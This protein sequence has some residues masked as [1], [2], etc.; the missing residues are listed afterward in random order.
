MSELEDQLDAILWKYDVSRAKREGEVEQRSSQ[1]A[2]KAQK[3]RQIIADVVKPVFDETKQKLAQRCVVQVTEGGWVAQHPANYVASIRVTLLP[4]AGASAPINSTSPPTLTIGISRFGDNV[5]IEA[6]TIKFPKK[7]TV[8]AISDLTQS[9]VV[10]VVAE[11][12]HS[13]FSG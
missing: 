11:F 3:K 10:A 8:L 1:E 4:K 9:R 12:V 13:V 2:T 6:K 5:E 7:R